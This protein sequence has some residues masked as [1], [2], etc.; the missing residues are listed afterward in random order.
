[1]AYHL[2][3]NNNLAALFANQGYAPADRRRYSLSQADRDLQA[4]TNSN[5][6]EGEGLAYGWGAGRKRR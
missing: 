4:R 1:M 2:P 3:P 5:R 6:P